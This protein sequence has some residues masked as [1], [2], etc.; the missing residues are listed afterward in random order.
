MGLDKVVEEV[1]ASGEKRRRDILADAESEAERLMDAAR[2]EVEEY[3]KRRTEENRL[4]MERLREQ[5]LQTAELEV[6]KLELAMRRDLLERVAADAKERLGNLDRTRTEALLKAILERATMPGGKVYSA[7]KDEGL[8]RAMTSMRY[9]GHIKCLG[10]VVV[11]S[12]DGS[13]R[14]DHTF[15]TLLKETSERNLPLIAGLLFEEG[16]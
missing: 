1:R 15:D 7:A 14:E 5:E 10:G 3:D 13:V 6:R 8:V 9:A 11:E 2:E 12:A 16:G 4:R